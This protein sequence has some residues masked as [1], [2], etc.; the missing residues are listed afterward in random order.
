MKNNSYGI[1]AGCLLMLMSSA[2]S[3]VTPH[4]NFQMILGQSVG[5]NIDAPPRITNAYADR[6]LSSRVLQTGNLENEYQWYGA[7]RYFYEIDSKTR[8]IVGWHFEGSER[9]CRINP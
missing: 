8:I 1:L 4:E 2:C 9:D 5:K 7:C 3:S 6:L